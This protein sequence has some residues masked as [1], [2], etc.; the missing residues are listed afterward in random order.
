[1]GRFLLFSALGAI[2]ILSPQYVSADEAPHRIAGFTLGKQVSDFADL[3]NMKT[4]LPLRHREYLS[5]V[6]TRDIPGY[7]SGYIIYGNCADPG[8]IVRIKLKYDYES[9]KFYDDLMERFK[10]RFG[11]PD[12]WRGD[13]FHVI[14]IWKWA[15]RDNNNHRITLHLQH[16]MDEEYK[17]GNSLKLTNMTL[18]DRERACREE[19]HPGSTDNNDQSSYKEKR[20]KEKDYQQFI[21]N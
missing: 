4:S 8:R 7:K 1:M 17:F 10:K 3:V 13:P 14:I 20:L 21:P 16:S 15:F 5:V 18:M 6:E 2:L 19:K 12:A 9:K 11:E